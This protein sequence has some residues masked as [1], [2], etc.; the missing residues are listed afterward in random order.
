VPGNKK[1]LYSPMRSP[2][3]LETVSRACAL[4][5]EF[6]DDRQ[7]LTLNEIVE[8]TGIER[9]ICFRLLRTLEDEG[10]LRR[11]ELRKYSSNVHILSGK[12][13]RIGYA[14]EGNDSFSSAVSQGLR[15]AATEFHIDLIELDNQFSSKAALR[16]AEMLVK[17]RVD[18]AIEFKCMSVSEPSFPTSFEK[19]PYRS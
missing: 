5:R 3:T 9:T 2:Y 1:S 4:L 13:F 18:L 14:S 17:Q 11:A 10:F 15:W 19:R 16:N 6:N 7:G 12:R 8:R